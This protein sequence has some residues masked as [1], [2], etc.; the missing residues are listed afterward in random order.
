MKKTTKATKDTQEV[1]I[2]AKTCYRIFKMTDEGHFIEPKED[3]HY[4]SY[5][6][7]HYSGY[8]SIDDAKD[9]IIE[10]RKTLKF[11][12]GTEYVVLPFISTTSV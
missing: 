7:D 6:F 10:Y 1:T 8:P 11:A 4:G 2:L 12:D 9:A 3:R 5:I